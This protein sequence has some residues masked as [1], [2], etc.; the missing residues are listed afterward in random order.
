MM[1]YEQFKKKKDQLE[2]QKANYKK[3]IDN[4]NKS[5][6][7]LKMDRLKDRVRMDDMKIVNP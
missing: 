6:Q 4:V 1:T 5:L 3:Q 7:R 2:M